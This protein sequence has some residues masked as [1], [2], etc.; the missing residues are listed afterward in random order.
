MAVHERDLP[1][2]RERLGLAHSVH[3][4]EPAQLALRRIPA[5]AAVPA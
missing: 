4:P 1:T 3:W 5:R 2:I